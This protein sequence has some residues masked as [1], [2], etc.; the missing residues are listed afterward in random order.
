MAAC[1]LDHP[2]LQKKMVE[3]EIFASSYGNFMVVR[4]GH[5]PKTLLIRAILLHMCR[6][7]VNSCRNPR[8]IYTY[9]ASSHFFVNSPVC[10]GFSRGHPSPTNGSFAS[11][12][13][14]VVLWWWLLLL[15]WH[16]ILPSWHTTDTLGEN[17][18]V[19]PLAVAAMAVTRC[20]LP[21]DARS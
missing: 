16:F 11:S 14:P 6:A 2:F 7:E 9:L 20:Q 21:L 19:L 15:S 4:G 12:D 17:L 5:Q 13:V 3:I 10:V 1:C 8:S 18:F